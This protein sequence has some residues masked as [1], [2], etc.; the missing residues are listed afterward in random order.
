MDVMSLSLQEFQKFSEVT[1]PDSLNRYMGG[2]YRLNQPFISGYWYLILQPPAMIFDAALNGGASLATAWFHSTAEGFTPPTQT[3]MKVDV[4][5]MGGTA[6]SF[7][8][9]R[10][11]NREF[12]ITFRE[13]QN[14]PISTAIRTWASVIDPHLGR[15][16]LKEF[17]PM[18]YKGSAYAILAKPTFRNDTTN[19]MSIDAGDIEQVYYMEG[20]MPTTVPDDSFSTDIATNDALQLSVT[21]SFD[22]SFFTKESPGVVANAISNLLAVCN[23]DDNSFVYSTS[24]MNDRSGLSGG[25]LN[26]TGKYVGPPGFG[27]T[28][29]P[30]S[31]S[32]Q[33]VSA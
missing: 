22:G 3:I 25:N 33:T 8:S 4:P 20:V 31:N 6:S 16:P 29:T 7:Y 15:S 11:T 9:G 12:T 24:S 18:Y 2:N 19:L 5:G 27:T 32:G 1:G 10:E 23:A 30:T 28:G 14:L 26:E 17:L 13:Y 21:F